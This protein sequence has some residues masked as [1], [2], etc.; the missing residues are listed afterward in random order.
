MAARESVASITISR[1]RKS[2]HR[3]PLKP[4]QTRT[5]F[6]ISSVHPFDHVSRDIVQLLSKPGGTLPGA[7]QVFPQSVRLFFE[8]VQQ[9]SRFVHAISDAVHPSRS[10]VHA[11]RLLV[12]SFPEAV[13]L[14]RPVV[15]AFPPR[16]TLRNCEPGTKIFASRN[17]HGIRHF[18]R[19]VNNST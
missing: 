1:L 3:S 16:R 12:R 6:T 8:P 19:I 4:I 11:W 15:P 7:V 9:F 14:S 10:P 18:R 13:H 17:I 2:L 5:R